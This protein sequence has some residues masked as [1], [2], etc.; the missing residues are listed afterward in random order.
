MILNG[1]GSGLQNHC[2]RDTELFD[3]AALPSPLNKLTRPIPSARVSKCRLF[4]NTNISN[5]YNKQTYKYKY[6]RQTDTDTNTDTNKIQIRIHVLVSDGSGTHAEELVLRYQSLRASVH[7]LT[8]RML[9]P[10]KQG[11]FPVTLNAIHR[12]H[13]Y[14]RYSKCEGIYSRK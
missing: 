2:G 3:S 9:V 11:G 6:N 7:S 12:F 1:L 10:Q 5:R 13:R 14:H 8:L 4:S